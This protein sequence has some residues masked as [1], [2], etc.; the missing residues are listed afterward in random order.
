MHDQLSFADS[1]A[2]R[3]QQASRTEGRLEDEDGI[4]AARFR[5]E[6][7]ARRFAA[8]LF[9]RSPEE[10]DAFAKWYFCVL[11]R[12]QREK[13]LN[14]SGLHVESSRPISFA[15]FQPERHFGECSCRVDRIVV[16]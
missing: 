15:A 9:V 4:A 7:L 16:A 2:R 14:D 12:L 3:F 5:F 11:N 13:R 6:E 10:D 1:L 8:D